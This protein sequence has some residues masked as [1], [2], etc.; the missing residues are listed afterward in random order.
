[1][2]KLVLLRVIIFVVLITV[3]FSMVTN[4]QAVNYANIGSVSGVNAYWAVTKPRYSDDE[5]LAAKAKREYGPVELPKGRFA[6]QILTGSAGVTI[7]LLDS[8]G[9][10][11]E[12]AE[13]FCTF[14]G[15]SAS[16]EFDVSQP[17][18]YKFVVQNDSNEKITYK[19]KLSKVEKKTD[20]V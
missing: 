19:H 10:T 5:E 20:V 2:K 1:M 6:F 9:K 14:W 3:Q 12:S 17:S 13:S 15:C 7:H 18:K 8:S 4:A 16:I 11:I